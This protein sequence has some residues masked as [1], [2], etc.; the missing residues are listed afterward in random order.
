MYEVKMPRLGVTM[1][2]GIITDW[3]VDEGEE[4]NKGDYLFELETEKS[5]LEI[6]AQEGGVLKKIL[7]PP[8]KEVPVNT[9]VAVIAG[10]DEEVDFSRYE[11]E[12][13]TKSPAAA[14]AAKGGEKTDPKRQSSDR[15]GGVAPRA[16]KLAKELGVSLEGITGTGKN[17]I[18][19]EKDVREASSGKEETKPSIRVKETIPL[20]GIQKTMASNMAKSWQNIPQFTQIV[21]VDMTRPMAVKK[22]LGNVSLNDIIIKAVS[23]AVHA[24]PFVNSRLGNDQKEVTVYEEVNVSVAVNSPDGLVVPVIK[25]TESKSVQDISAEVR[26]LAEK[27]EKKSLSMEDYA[28]GTITVSNLGSFGI[29]TGTPIINS[30]QA[31]I[32]FAGAVKKTPIV[33]ENDDIKVAPIMML[34]VCYDHRFIDGVKGAEFTG[35]LK[36]TF[37]TLSSDSLS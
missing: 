15:Q 10:A 24:H 5:N 35:E 17:G 12:E 34:S 26:K 29:E 27:A 16:R 13:A 25:N 37:E 23:N 4:V 1:Q 32:V 7:V 6:E 11:K 3:L 19:T 31:A 2:N 18:I 21:S 30:P 14:E 9:V 28:D 8:G 36:K 20:T 22:E 33:D